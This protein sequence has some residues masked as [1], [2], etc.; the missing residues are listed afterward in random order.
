MIP[1]LCWYQYRFLSHVG[2]LK[3][4]P[5]AKVL[6]GGGLLDPSTHSIPDCYGSF[7]PTAIQVSQLALH[8]TI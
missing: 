1:V 3:R 8:I 6:F 5:G 4:I 2:A 7:E